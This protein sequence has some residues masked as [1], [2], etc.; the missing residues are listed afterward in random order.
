MSETLRPQARCPLTGGCELAPSSVSHLTCITWDVRH[1]PTDD[2]ITGVPTVSPAHLRAPA[3]LETACPPSNRCAA[4]LATMTCRAEYPF[5]TVQRK[6]IPTGAAYPLA[7]LRVPDPRLSVT[8][9]YE[10][11]VSGQFH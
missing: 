2:V 9:R 7:G 11:A 4:A 6:R 3:S 8:L 10:A 5:G 1:R